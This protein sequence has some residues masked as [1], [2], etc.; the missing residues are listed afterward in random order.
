MGNGM[1]MCQARSG[2]GAGS[3]TEIRSGGF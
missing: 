2:R 1:T 3:S